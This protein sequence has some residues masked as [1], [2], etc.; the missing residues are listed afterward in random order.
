M[1]KI[2]TKCFLLTSLLLLSLG[3]IIGCS[4]PTGDVEKGSRWYTMNNCSECHGLKGSDGRSPDITGLD[5]SYYSFVKRL[6]TENSITMP[7]F[8]ESKISEQDAADLLAYINTL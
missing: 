5:M 4:G 7:V 1:L 2:I 8:P 3:F 6:R